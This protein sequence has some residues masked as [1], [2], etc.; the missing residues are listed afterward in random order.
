[1]ARETGDMEQ[2][3]LRVVVA[4]DEPIV[5]MNL[6]DMMALTGFEVVAGVADGFEAIQACRKNEVDIVLLD[7][8]MPVLDGIT[9]AQCIHE[10]G[11]AD[12]IVMVT[13]YAEDEMVEKAGRAGVSGFLIKPVDERSLYATIQ[14]AV[15]RSKELRQLRGEVKAV[16]E[17]LEARKTIERAKGYIME[18]RQMS[19]PEAFQF[20]R[21]ISKSKNI[22]M[23]QVARV[24][25]KAREG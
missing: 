1:M 19:E 7:I 14:V 11:L 23:A 9:A 6:C 8:E 18:R 2:G 21:D 13:A 5:N 22:S 25:L 20:I 24:L 3:K 10:E 12:T 4:D 16:A 17:Q 15:A